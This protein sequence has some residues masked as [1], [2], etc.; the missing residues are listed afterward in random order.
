[1]RAEYPQTHNTRGSLSP[2]GFQMPGIGRAFRTRNATCSPIW[3]Q[4]RRFLYNSSLNSF[5]SVDPSTVC[6]YAIQESA[7]GLFPHGSTQP[8]LLTQSGSAWLQLPFLESIPCI[9]FDNGSPFPSNLYLIIFNEA[10]MRGQSRGR[11]VGFAC[12]ASV[13][14]GFTDSDPGHGHGTARWAVLRWHP[15]CHNWKDPHL[16]YTTM[17][18]GNLGRKSN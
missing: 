2:R 12:S 18:W 9:S 6:V 15:T 4:V 11:V 5:L 8:H 3:A 17:Y 16:K 10:L 14:Q 1:M 7:L 13:A